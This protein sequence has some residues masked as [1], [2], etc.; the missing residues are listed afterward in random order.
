MGTC[1]RPVAH[2]RSVVGALRGAAFRGGPMRRLVLVAVASAMT[3][4]AVSGCSAS[5]PPTTSAKPSRQPGVMSP[6]ARPDKTRDEVTAD[7]RAAG[8]GLGAYT[9]LNS[10]LSP[11]VCMVTARRLSGRG[12]TVRDAE[13]VARR[14][15]HR[16]WKVGL[17]KPESIALTSGGWHA[18]L[19]TTDIPDEN[20]VSELAPYK[21]LLVLTASGKCGR[22]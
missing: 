16:G 21:G 10:L 5:T 6:S 15:Q 19:G 9:D 12:F 22:R 18:A 7:L 17:V 14:L 11:G 4:V 8:Q 20:R 13:L 1:S 3:A 2:F